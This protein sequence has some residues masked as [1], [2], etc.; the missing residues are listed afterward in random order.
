M[1]E[2]PDHPQLYLITPRRFALKEFSE[3]LVRVMEATPVACLRLDLESEDVGEI[4]AMADALRELAHARD[5]PLVITQ[6]FRLAERLGLD[7]VHLND[8][9]KLVRDL[10]RDWG[11]GQIIGADGGL[12]KHTGMNLG[13]AGS[14][15]VSFGPVTAE[16]DLGTGAVVEPEVF[17]WWSDFVELPVVA[18]GGVKLETARDLAPHVDFFAL[19]AEVWGAEDPVAVVKGYAEALKG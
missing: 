16:R 18:E 19:G 8:A 14:D 3:V 1:T 11:D 4:S 9:P 10:R 12:S 6:H 5:V 15:Y 2:A 7:G 17:A 13:E